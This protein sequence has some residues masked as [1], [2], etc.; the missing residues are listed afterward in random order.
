[1]ATAAPESNSKEDKK[2]SVVLDPLERSSEVLFGVIMVMTFTVSLR[3]A[4]ADRLQVHE[5]LIG[6]LGCNLAWGL[7]DAIMYIMACV[8]ERGHSIK[9]LRRVHKVKEQPQQAN[10]ILAE[11]LPSMVAA[12]LPPPALDMMRERLN[13]LP[14]PPAHPRL[15]PEDWRGAFS[16]FLLV[17]LSTFPIILPFIVLRHIKLA[18][19]ISDVI[20]LVIL[21]FSGYSYGK[22]AGHTAWGW[23]IS[24]V[25]LGCI[26]VGLTIGLG[27]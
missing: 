27:G 26:M 10:Q 16:V 18:A 25:V 2:S 7:I 15:K 19:R 13:A 24:M 12:V 8:S 6:A 17:F 21:F 22:Y 23:G 14:E 9:V 5:M 11:E 4:R 3:V 1:M 20:A